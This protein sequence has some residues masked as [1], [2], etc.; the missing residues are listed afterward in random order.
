MWIGLSCS[1]GTLFGGSICLNNSL[2]ARALSIVSDVQLILCLPVRLCVGMFAERSSHVSVTFLVYHCWQSEDV[3]KLLYT[4]A[5]TA[6]RHLEYSPAVSMGVSVE[7]HFRKFNQT[8][9]IA[10]LVDMRWWNF[11]QLF[12]SLIEECTQSAH[13][14][15][16]HGQTV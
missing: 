7:S 1:N 8:R 3:P 12:E 9:I 15:I 13:E 11:E 10:L 16:S 6:F 5:H 4:A 14:V 2:D